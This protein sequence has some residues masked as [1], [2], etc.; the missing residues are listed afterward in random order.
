MVVLFGQQEQHRAAF[1]GHR[2]FGPCRRRQTAERRRNF[3]H[4][5]SDAVRIKTQL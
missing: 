1:P 4:F 3:G 5:H 2:S